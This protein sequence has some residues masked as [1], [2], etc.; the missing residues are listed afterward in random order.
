M[1]KRKKS[2]TWGPVPGG[3]EGAAR[4]ALRL[5]VPLVY[6]PK[7]WAPRVSAQHLTAAGGVPGTALWADPAVSSGTGH[8]WGLS[9][10]LQNYFS[11]ES[12]CYGELKTASRRVQQFAFESSRMLLGRRKLSVGKSGI[13]GDIFNIYRFF[14]HLI[15]S[16]RM[17]PCNCPGLPGQREET[18]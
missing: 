2:I 11:Y 10:A 14:L 18:L 5:P 8:G 7:E 15:L 6:L 1:W 16:S 9:L 13:F 12:H 4:R 17:R 3:G